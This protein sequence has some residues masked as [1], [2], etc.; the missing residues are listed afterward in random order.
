MKLWIT[1]FGKLFWFTNI[2]SYNCKVLNIK[3]FYYKEKNPSVLTE[4]KRCN[5]IWNNNKSHPSITLS[6]LSGKLY[7]VVYRY[8]RALSQFS[9]QII[10]ILKN[11]RTAVLRWSLTIHRTLYT[12]LKYKSALFKT[13]YRSLFCKVNGG[14]CYGCALFCFSM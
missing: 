4:W 13:M 2:T 9:K 12:T 14:V 11:T 8:P 6:I 10:T 5:S 1:T 3:E 7:S